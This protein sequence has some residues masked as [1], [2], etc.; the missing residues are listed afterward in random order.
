MANFAIKAAAG[1]DDAIQFAWNGF[2]G[3]LAMP[4]LAWPA[5]GGNTGAKRNMNVYV[6]LVDPTGSIAAGGPTTGQ[7]F[8]V[9]NR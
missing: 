6:P 5:T 3:T 7:L 4:P 1:G 2:T 8:P 9:G